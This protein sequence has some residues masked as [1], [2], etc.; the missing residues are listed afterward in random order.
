MGMS[1]QDTYV[2]NSPTLATCDQISRSI[3]FPKNLSSGPIIISAWAVLL[4]VVAV[5]YQS[6][7][8]I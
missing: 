1:L 3:P 7:N 6:M 8:I 2:I 5:H 4:F